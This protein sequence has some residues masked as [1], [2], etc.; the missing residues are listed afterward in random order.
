[1]KKNLAFCCCLLL[2]AACQSTDT[3]T[4]S[5]SSNANGIITNKTV[6]APN[7]LSKLFNPNSKVF[8]GIDFAATPAVVKQ[9]ETADP[10]KSP[11][12][13]RLKYSLDLDGQNFADVQYE[14]SGNV[15]QKIQ[16]DIFTTQLQQAQTLYNDL[17]A[18]FDQKYQKRK[19]LWD[20][21]ENGS[22]Y[23][24]FVKLM[25]KPSNSGIYIVWERQ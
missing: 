25:S 15:L 22:N 7:S 23:T 19:K 20:A 8:R 17:Q 18:F 12:S 6:T 10:L 5:N 14:F 11:T 13:N 9:T 1:M 4:I 16:V 21:S 2:L 24:A 3:A